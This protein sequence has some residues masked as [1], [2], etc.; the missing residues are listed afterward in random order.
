MKGNHKFLMTDPAFAEYVFHCMMNTPKEHMLRLGMTEMRLF[1][2]QHTI[3]DFA[4]NASLEARLYMLSRIN[5]SYSIVVT[6]DKMELEELLDTLDH[7]NNL[8]ERLRVVEGMARDNVFVMGSRN[9][10]PVLQLGA[11]NSHSNVYVLN[12]DY[13][14]LQKEIKD[15]NL[16]SLNSKIVLAQKAFDFVASVS[17]NV[18]AN[19]DFIQSLCGV[20]HISL[21]ILIHL[22]LNRNKFITI[23]AMYEKLNDYSAPNAGANIRLKCGRLA[24]TGHI[25]ASS[26]AKG[27]TYCIMD[28]GIDVVTTFLKHII[29]E[30]NQSKN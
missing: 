27:K 19:K 14:R 15:N 8:S 30:H 20:D 28:A 18:L 22:Y 24:K 7:P 6:P 5:R 26:E 23:P 12:Y 16:E 29:R 13:L 2:T 21:R 10:L 1:K 11:M 17:A 9:L 4:Q 25:L 3:R